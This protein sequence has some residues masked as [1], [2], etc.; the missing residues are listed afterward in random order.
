MIQMGSLGGMMGGGPS[1]GGMDRPGSLLN[2]IRAAQA[3]P[4]QP[5]VPTPTGAYV[6]KRMGGNSD[7]GVWYEPVWDPNAGPMTTNPNAAA[8]AAAPA[9]V[10]PLAQAAVQRAAAAA[11]PPILTDTTPAPAAI[12]GSLG[13]TAGAGAATSGAAASTAPTS[14]R[15]RRAPNQG[16][17]A[18]LLGGGETAEVLGV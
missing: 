9:G 4:P 10:V 14:S 12:I 8:P 2:R 16:R 1:A 11:Q 18:T 17:A 3:A 13:E 7:E 15:R 5:F 6:Q